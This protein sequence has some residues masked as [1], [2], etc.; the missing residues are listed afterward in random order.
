MEMVWD[1]A[2]GQALRRREVHSRVGGGSRQ[3]GIA[4]VAGSPEI[5]VFTDPTSGAHHGYDRFEGLR[6][7][8]TYAYTGEGQNGDQV[9]QRGNRALRDAQAERRNIR[10]FRTAGVMATYVGAFTLGDPAFEVRRIP[11]TAGPDRDGI[12]FNLEPIEAAALEVLPA[13]G[14]FE[15]VT[16]VRDW[17]APSSS[18]YF[19]AASSSARAAMRDEFRLQAQFGRWLTARGDRVKVLRLATTGTFIEP[20]LYNSSTGEVI[21]A[22]RSV[23]RHD[24]RMAI[25]QVLDYASVARLNGF[26]VAPSI[27]LPARPADDLLELCHSLGITIWHSIDGNFKRLSPL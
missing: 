21:E 26:D 8:G 13:Y 12:I 20:D 6:E 11:S 7:D 16:G 10:L 15:K 5:L 4:P 22:K 2:V 17:V 23:A 1:I 9:F 25:G 18:E 24:V 19:T 27:L 14:G 3:N